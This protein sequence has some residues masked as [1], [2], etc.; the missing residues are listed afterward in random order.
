MIPIFYE[1]DNVHI[2]G[3]AALVSLWTPRLEKKFI[4]IKYFFII[5][6]MTLKNIFA[7]LGLNLAHPDHKSI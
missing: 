7:Q 1:K 6:L 4:Y 5:N 3:A 2:V